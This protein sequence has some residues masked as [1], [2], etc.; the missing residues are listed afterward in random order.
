MPDSE[1]IGF[2]GRGW[3][4]AGV[5][6]SKSKC[7]GTAVSFAPKL[8]FRALQAPKSRSQ[9]RQSR[10]RGGME[11][12]QAAFA[13]QQ[14]PSSTQA[15]IKEANVWLEQFQG[16]T[17]AWQVADQLLALDAAGNGLLTAAQIFA[18]QTMRAKI[19]YDFAELPTESHHSLRNSLLGHV[20]R[21]APVR[22]VGL[23]GRPAREPPEPAWDRASVVLL[24][25]ARPR[26]NLAPCLPHRRRVLSRC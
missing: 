24:L 2:P 15:Q 12:V 6:F 14:N 18:A 16:T 20:V 26:R 7:C 10:P 3:K 8:L 5:V 1:K 13:C 25:C 11:R 19:Q 17:E 21:F 23:P 22:T 9:R 4:A